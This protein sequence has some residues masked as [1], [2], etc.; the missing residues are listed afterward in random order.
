MIGT[1]IA[2]W[3]PMQIPAIASAIHRTRP[4]AMNTIPSIGTM[5]T[6]ENGPK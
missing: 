2:T 6:A 5:T 4:S 3:P 1:A